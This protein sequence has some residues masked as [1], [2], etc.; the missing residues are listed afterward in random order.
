MWKTREKQPIFVEKA[1]FFV[2][3]PLE[4]Q[5]FLVEKYWI[6]CGLPGPN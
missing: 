1:C 2:D 4:K 6:D 3:K 5:D